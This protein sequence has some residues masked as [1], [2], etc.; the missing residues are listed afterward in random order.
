MFLVVLGGVSIL[1]CQSEIV[2]LLFLI[3]TIIRWLEA[4][5]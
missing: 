5:T 4:G 3:L 1:L 2:D